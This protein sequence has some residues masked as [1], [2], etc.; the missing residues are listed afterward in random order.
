MREGW[1]A[2]RIAVLELCITGKVL[3]GIGRFWYEGGAIYEALCVVRTVRPFP[4]RSH[5]RPYVK[6]ENRVTSRDIDELPEPVKDAL[7]SCKRLSHI[8]IVASAALFLL[9]VSPNDA[10]DYRRFAAQVDSLIPSPS[11]RRQAWRLQHVQSMYREHMKALA[12]TV[13]SYLPGWRSDF[14]LMP[15]GGATEHY[16]WIAGTPPQQA[17]PA[18]ATRLETLTVGDVAPYYEE[19]LDAFP[20]QPHPYELSDTL[21]AAST[22]KCSTCDVLL[23]FT[24]DTVSNTMDVAWERVDADG[25]SRS[26]AIR[27]A[28]EGDAFREYRVVAYSAVLRDRPVGG[29]ELM[30]ANLDSL[31]REYRTDLLTRTAALRRLAVESPRI[32]REYRDRPASEAVLA[33]EAGA[34]SRQ[35]TLSLFGLD[36]TE[37]AALMGGPAIL[38]TLLFLLCAHLRHAAAIGASGESTYAWPPLFRGWMGVVAGVFMLCVMPATAAM[39]FA[40]R[41]SADVVAGIVSRNSVAVV[42]VL[43]SVTCVA[44]SIGC[45]TYW[46]PLR[47]KAGSHSRESQPA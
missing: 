11:A 34:A 27:I 9:G 17:S 15:V 26:A 33:A 29:I 43:L 6:R 8:A 4:Q 14:A 18:L 21:Q 39:V 13:N 20:Y 38:A 44:L 1:Y 23:S 42:G 19:L 5:S 28:A 32:W 16:T 47:V 10:S 12:D 46:R 7:D 25:S 2:A 36:L 31:E 40:A 24:I 22:R 3:C 30:T 41:I 37:S 45:L 35:A